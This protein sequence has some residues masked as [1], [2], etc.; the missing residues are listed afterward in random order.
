MLQ[1]DLNNRFTSHA[2]MGLDLVQCEKIRAAGRD[3]AILINVV[4]PE[5]REKSLAVTNIEKAVFWANAAI[6][7]QYS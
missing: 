7:R 4:C 1:S 6:A 2:L 5:G 3:F